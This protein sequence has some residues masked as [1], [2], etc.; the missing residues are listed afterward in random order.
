VIR[1][2]RESLRDIESCLRSMQGKLYDLGFRG[3][4]ALNDARRERIHDRRIFA[5][6]A[7]VLTA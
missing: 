2:R 6:F 4:V 7:Q 3:K 1:S 5:D